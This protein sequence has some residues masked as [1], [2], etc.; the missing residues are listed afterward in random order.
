MEENIKLERI[1]KSCGVG[2]K[3]T[4]IFCIIAIVGCVLSLIAGFTILNMGKDFDAK[5]A[6]WNEYGHMSVGNSIGGIKMLHINLE[7]PSS[8][9]SDIP[10]I[11]EAIKD[12]PYAVEVSMFA[13]VAAMLTAIMAVLFKLIGSVFSLIRKEDNPFTDK[14]IRRIVIVMTVLSV[15]IFFS[16][17]MGYGI[18]VGIL[19]WVVYTVLDYGRTLQIQSDETL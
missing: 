15:I 17:G 7:D 16:S 14:V 4:M 10:A 6:A 8:L 1:K 18:L 3:V 5:F 2:E 13:F 11:S 19:T 12:H 9:E